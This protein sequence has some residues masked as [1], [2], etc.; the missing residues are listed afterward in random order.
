MRCLYRQVP[1]ANLWSHL[2]TGLSVPARG[3][4]A[5][6][7]SS[8]VKALLSQCRLGWW[9][10]RSPLLGWAVRVIREGTI[11]SDCYITLDGHTCPAIVLTFRDATRYVKAWCSGACVTRFDASTLVLAADDATGL[12]STSLAVW[13]FE[14]DEREDA[15]QRGEQQHPQHKPGCSYSGHNFSPSW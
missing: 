10:F 1:L 11:T 13:L 5:L 7:R 8:F 6:I 9:L 4:F 14:T 15:Q 3:A 12:N 2:T